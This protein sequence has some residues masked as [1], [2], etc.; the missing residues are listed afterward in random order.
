MTDH[1]L[2]NI[3]LNG[4]TPR[5]R[6][7]MAHYEDLRSD[8]SKWKE[9]LLHMDF[10][11]TEF[12]TEEKDNRCKAQVKKR[13]LNERIQLK[14]GEIGSEKKKVEFVIK[15][16]WDKQKEEVRCMK[17]RRTNHQAR[18]SKDP[19]GAK[20]PP[21]NA[22]QE[23]VLKKRKFNSGH[24]KIT[25]IRSEMDSGNESGVHYQTLDVLLDT[26]PS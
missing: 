22:N 18:D 12:Q 17:C 11:T 16:V 3:I 24:L 5:L 14:G 6:Q 20:T 10:I 15:E 7:A 13:G 9:K 2:I 1:N 19:L 4:I 8:P 23:P 21:G 26:P 25:E